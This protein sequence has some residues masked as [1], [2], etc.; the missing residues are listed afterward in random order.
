MGDLLE[1]IYMYRKRCCR[2]IKWSQMEFKK[3]FYSGRDYDYMH[4]K[5]HGP[6][7]SFYAIQSNHL[8]GGSWSIV[9]YRDMPSHSVFIPVRKVFITYLST[10]PKMEELWEIARKNTLRD[11][12]CLK[13]IWI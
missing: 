4:T 10:K 11:Y 7:N 5:W 8:R 12:F 1:L 3:N 6:Y 9:I 13:T 2:D